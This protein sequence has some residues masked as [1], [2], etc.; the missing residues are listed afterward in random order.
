M[1][2]YPIHTWNPFCFY[3]VQEKEK[4][5]L[6]SKREKDHARDR[7]ILKRSDM[8]TVK[9]DQNIEARLNSPKYIQH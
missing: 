1:H 3:D 8:E 7:N 5:N 6:K 4:E 9:V 2:L